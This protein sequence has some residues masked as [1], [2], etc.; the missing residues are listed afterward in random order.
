MRHERWLHDL[1]NE[2][3]VLVVEGWYLPEPVP[4]F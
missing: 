3:P 2:E 4:A 1:K